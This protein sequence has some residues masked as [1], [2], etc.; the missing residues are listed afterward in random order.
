MSKFAYCQNKIDSI[1]IKQTIKNVVFVTND[2]SYK[3][4]KIVQQD[5]VFEFTETLIDTVYM[6]NNKTYKLYYPNRTAHI[7]IK[8]DYQQGVDTI[9]NYFSNGTKDNSNKNPLIIHEELMYSYI[10]KQVGEPLLNGNDSV[11]RIILPCE[12]VN[13]CNIFKI[14]R[15]NISS[16][17]IQLHTLT[18]GS[19]DSLGI[20]PFNRKISIIKPKDAKKL[21][22]F[23]GQA[24]DLSDDNC[25]NCNEGNPWILES[26]IGMKYNRAVISV[27]CLRNKPQKSS[28]V[29]IFNELNRIAFKYVPYNCNAPAA[30]LKLY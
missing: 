26:K 28:F 22:E 19:Y 3:Y 10:L 17:S 9:F 5:G 15:F 8:W 27:L 16:N 18:A 14:V 25:R 7:I 6:R 13:I 20:K 12:D 21:Y 30:V 1:V 29:E 23:I 2:T 24:K 4:T 11:F